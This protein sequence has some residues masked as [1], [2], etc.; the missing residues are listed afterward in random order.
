MYIQ[1]MKYPTG[2]CLHAFALPSD[3]LINIT[4]KR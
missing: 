3:T 2:I 1:D 4:E